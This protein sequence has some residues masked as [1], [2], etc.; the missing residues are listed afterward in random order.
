MGWWPLALAALA[1]GGCGRYGYDAVPA[2]LTEV[3]GGERPDAEPPLGAFGPP[4]ELTEL[5]SN[6]AHD[7]DPTLTGD[8]LEIYFKA[9]RGPGRPN[10]FRA[11][12]ADPTQPFSQPERVFELS[13]EEYDGTPEVSLDG[14][15]ITIATSRAGGPGGVDIWRATRASRLDPWSP[16]V[17]LAELSSE[18][19]DYAAVSDESD[20]AALLVRDLDDGV[21]MAILGARRADRDDAWGEPVALPELADPGYDADAVLDASGLVVLF[22][23]ERAGGAGQRDLWQ[24]ARAGLD[25]PFSPPV[26]VEGLNGPGQ[27]EDPWI[28]PDLRTVVFA[29]DDGGGQRLF[30]A[31][32]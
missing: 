5:G 20:T 29:R 13:S 6:S 27:D 7:D 28:S 25:Q 11:V 24:A 21:G 17:P 8:L 2:D 32:R 22:V 4:T 15:S 30:I 12:R 14:L 9:E 3:D 31:T 19:D 26:P 23:S 10:I 1:L 16:P 18:R